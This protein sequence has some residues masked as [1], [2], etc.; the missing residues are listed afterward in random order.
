[1]I[2]ASVV[3]VSIVLFGNLHARVR[4]IF[5]ASRRAVLDARPQDVEIPDAD[6]SR[7]GERRKSF[8]ASVLVDGENAFL[9]SAPG[10]R[11]AEETISTITTTRRPAIRN[12]NE[13]ELRA[14]L[15]EAIRPLLVSR[16]LSRF[17]SLYFLRMTLGWIITLPRASVLRPRDYP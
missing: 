5:S 14:A 8:R 1:M 10:K 13:I 2:F 12:E 4:E 17:V 9:R 6:F 3:E 11:P 15:S 7:D 16:S